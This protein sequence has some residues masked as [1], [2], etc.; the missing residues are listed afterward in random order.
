M[1]GDQAEPVGPD[2]AL[3]IA[4]AE[5][6]DGG[7]LIGHVG[8][9]PVLLA[10]RGADVFA[11]GARCS[12]YGGP[13]AEGL[14]VDGTVRCPWHHACFDLRTGEVDSPPAKRAVRTHGV[15]VADGM[16]YVVPSAAAPCPAPGAMAGRA[17]GES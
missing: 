16:I 5:L 10:R 7:K 2:L 12:H 6:A 11:I 17:R 9:E 1:A 15:V 3:G 13:L 14:V 8:G 4:A